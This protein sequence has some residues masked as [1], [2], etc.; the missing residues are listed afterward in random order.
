M[1]KLGQTKKRGERSGLDMSKMACRV[2]SQKDFLRVEMVA[3][4]TILKEEG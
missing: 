1:E 3:S 2:G 4:N